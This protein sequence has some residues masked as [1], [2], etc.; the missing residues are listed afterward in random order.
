MNRFSFSQTSYNNFRSSSGCNPLN[1]NCIHLVRR[2]SI[3]SI[4]FVVQKINLI[5]FVL[6]EASHKIC[7]ITLRIYAT[8]YQICIKK[9][10][11]IGGVVRMAK[12]W[13]LWSII[14]FIGLSTFALMCLSAALFSALVVGPAMEKISTKLGK[15]IT[16]ERLN[17]NS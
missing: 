7:L 8:Q 4:G 9:Y 1:S 17:S 12:L 15:E 16:N 14:R 3:V 10:F 6:D 11:M 2:V 13:R 5:C